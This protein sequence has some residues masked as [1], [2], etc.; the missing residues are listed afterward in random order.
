MDVLNTYGGEVTGPQ[1]GWAVF[2]GVCTMVF[3][4]AAIGFIADRAIGLA[5]LSMVMV[6]VML[7]ATIHA[8]ETRSEPVRHE[9]TLRE[10]YVIDAEK[11][12]IIEKRGAIY[13]IE[14]RE[15][16]QS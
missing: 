7:F 11:Y 8:L 2:F 10:G 15:V 1:D 6:C 3:V 12:E 16:P 14:E 9:V 4:I 13:V 5:A